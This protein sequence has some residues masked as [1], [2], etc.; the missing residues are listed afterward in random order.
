METQQ[1]EK[2]LEKIYIEAWSTSIPH[3]KRHHQSL[4]AV[5]DHACK[6]RDAKIEELERQINVLKESW[7]SHIC[8]CDRARK[9]MDER[10]INHFA[11][12]VRLSHMEAKDAERLQQ[13]QELEKAIVRYKSQ[14]AERDA[15]IRK[16]KEEKKDLGSLLSQY[17]IKE[18]ELELRISCRDSQKSFLDQW[19]GDDLLNEWFDLIEYP[20]V[21]SHENYKEKFPVILKKFIHHVTTNQP[22]RKE[23]KWCEHWK[24]E[25]GDIWMHKNSDSDG[26]FLYAPKDSKFCPYC[27]APRPE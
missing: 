10:D 12:V 9:L 5:A 7:N 14:M 1:T 19:T 13:V 24:Q 23:K 17:Q 3:S 15:E 27:G 2:T 8:V 22:P 18:R 25:V 20:S 21:K 11:G 6:E 26:V 4:Q 16:L